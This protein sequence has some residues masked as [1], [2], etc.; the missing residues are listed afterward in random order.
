MDNGEGEKREREW[1]LNH[2][3]RTSEIA[4]LTTGPDINDN[5]VSR[6]VLLVAS[7]SLPPDGGG[8]VV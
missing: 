5:L 2:E 3:S 8:S 4:A 6:V 1:G 7:S